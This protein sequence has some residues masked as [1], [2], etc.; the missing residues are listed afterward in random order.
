MAGFAWV[1]VA[2]SG[3]ENRARGGNFLALLWEEG[4]RFLVTLVLY[5]SYLD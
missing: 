3:C 4:N 1:C 5:Y 2:L